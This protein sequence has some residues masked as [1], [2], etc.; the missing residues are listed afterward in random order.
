MNYITNSDLE[1]LAEV[2]AFTARPHAS[3]KKIVSKM[4]DGSMTVQQISSAAA[5]TVDV[6]V[7]VTDKT[8]LDTLCAD[9]E[10]I[11]IN[12]FGTAYTGI[13]SSEEIRWEPMIMSDAIYKGEFSLAVIE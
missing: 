10:I 13:I 11:T 3:T 5:V 9:C 4:L 6:V 12:H 1:T 8:A 2:R 7:Y